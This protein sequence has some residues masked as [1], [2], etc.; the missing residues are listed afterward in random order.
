MKNRFGSFQGGWRDK[1]HLQKEDFSEEKN[2]VIL[3][4][5]GSTE[6]NRASIHLGEDVR[7]RVGDPVHAQCRRVYTNKNVITSK[8]PKME[9]VTVVSPSKKRRLRSCD[10][11][12]DSASRCLFSGQQEKVQKNCVKKSS[13]GR[14]IPVSTRLI[15]VSTRLRLSFTRQSMSTAGSEMVL[16][17]EMSSAHW[18]LS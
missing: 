3:G 16:G 12:V 17:P 5:K 9:H 1:C 4:K 8:L 7:A 13:H 6:I 18:C 2:K 10:S 11:S 14:L 15:P